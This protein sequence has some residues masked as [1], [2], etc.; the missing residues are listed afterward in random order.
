MTDQEIS[1]SYYM[2]MIRSERYI[3]LKRANW[4]S[5][6]ILKSFRTPT[7]MT[8]FKW[9]GDID[10]V[11]TPADSIRYYKFFLHSG[12]MSME[13][14]TG[15][16]KAYVGDINFYHFKY[17]NVMQT[18]RQVGSTF[19]PIIYTL[20]MMPGGYSPCHLVPNISVSFPMPNGQ[21]EYSPRLTPLRNYEGKMIP[22]WVG[23]A[24]SVNQISAWVLKQYGPAA[25]I[26]LARRMGIRSYLPEVPSIC[27]GAAEIKLSEMVGAYG[28]FA[29][30]GV[31]SEPIV[32][33]RLE[34]KNGNVL[35]TLKSKKREV[36]SEG[37]AY[38]MISLMRGVIQIG[39]STSI[40]WKYKLTNDIAGKTGTTNNNS[41]AWFIGYVPNLVTGV[42]VG[43]EER[44]IR[45]GSGATG[46]GASAAL[47]IWAL[48]MQRVYKDSKL[49][50]SKAN[51]E[52][53]QSS[54]GSQA[55]CGKS[56]S[57]SNDERYIN[58]E[59]VY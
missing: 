25:A 16:I 5:A 48:Y 33:T 34:D 7:H 3:M 14:Q 32:V 4:D 6:A 52:P 58:I 30:K 38:R 35:A 15:Y 31:Y 45:F 49:E 8:V 59:E 53:P 56:E 50:V 42:W 2:S 12:L 22:L 24:L 43:G 26:D 28:T 36:I 21:P 11:M 46:Q 57:T 37:T 20:A 47:P 19:K 51:F 39:T 27:V 40:K 41:D 23:L 18:R 13:P 55:D 29:N 54:D 17:D 1:R 44:S 9:T 10:T